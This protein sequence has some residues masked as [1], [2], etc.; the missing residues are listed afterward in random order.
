MSGDI[1][2]SIRIPYSLCKDWHDVAG[3]SSEKYFSIIH[4]YLIENHCFNLK[5]DTH[6]RLGGRLRRECPRISN[7]FKGIRGKKS[8]KQ[9]VNLNIRREELLMFPEVE[10]MHVALDDALKAVHSAL[11]D[12]LKAVHG[13]LDD[14]LKAVHVAL[15]DAL[16]AVHV[17]LD[18]AL[19]AVHG[20]LDDALKAVHVALDDALK[21]VH[22]ALDD[23]LKAVH[24][25]LG[26]SMVLTF[27]V[28]YIRI[29]S[30]LFWDGTPFWDFFAA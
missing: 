22:V 23:A 10:A 4:E 5:Q 15:D 6:P 20:A 9:G 21:A 19:K 29:K 27:R 26:H 3:T 30:L 2:Y 1:L 12:A 16:K 25:A 24:G 14:A 18:D 13:A 7:K 11:D 17:A 28:H 8:V